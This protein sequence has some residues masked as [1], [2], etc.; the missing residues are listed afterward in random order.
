ML[1]RA[2]SATRYAVNTWIADFTGVQ[3]RVT[4]LPALPATDSALVEKLVMEK[5]RVMAM[6]F[7]VPRYVESYYRATPT[8]VLTFV[9]QDPVISAKRW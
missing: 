9:T 3:A 1:M 8:R 6:W 7:C 5:I 2:G 4:N